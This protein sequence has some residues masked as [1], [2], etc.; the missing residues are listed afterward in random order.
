MNNKE[1]EELLAGIMQRT[2]QLVN[3]ILDTI[4]ATLETVSTEIG[5]IQV[6]ALPVIKQVLSAA[7]NIMPEDENGKHIPTES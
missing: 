7:R 2:E 3:G 1:A 6:V 5:G 4:E